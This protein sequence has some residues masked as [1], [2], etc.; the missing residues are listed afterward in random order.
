VLVLQ[1]ALFADGGMTALGANVLNM[2][3]IAPLVASLVYRAMVA[4]SSSRSAISVAAFV[5]AAASVIAAAMA[6]SLELAVSGTQPLSAVF[7]PM[8]SVHALIGVAEGLITVAL[9]AAMTHIGDAVPR[10]KSRG[11]AFAL[12]LA[13]ITATLLAPIGS[14]SLDALERVASDLG[15]SSLATSAWTGVAQDYV[16][17]GISWEFLAIGL[18]GLLGMTAVYV[19]AAIVGRTA[20]IRIRKTR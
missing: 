5:A 7:M 17:P 18:S 11:A 16:M 12:P 3:V 9:V 4:R 14:Q 10:T 15:F 13:V 19:S 8:L 6:C 20:P 1:C 2:A